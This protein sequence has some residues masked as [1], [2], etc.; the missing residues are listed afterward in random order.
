MRELHVSADEDAPL[1]VVR[2]ALGFCVSR[3]LF[4]VCKSALVQGMEKRKETNAK[5]KKDREEL[6]EA[7][8]RAVLLRDEMVWPGRGGF[9]FVSEK[10]SGGEEG[11]KGLFVCVVIVLCRSGHVSTWEAE[12]FVTFVRKGGDLVFVCV[13]WV[14]DGLVFGRQYHLVHVSCVK[15]LLQKV[16]DS[17]YS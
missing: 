1:L 11:Y 9:A 15:A 7:E 10:R 3:F 12:H 6:L 2:G 8:C 13:G 14:S 5:K 4:C 17:A 16:G